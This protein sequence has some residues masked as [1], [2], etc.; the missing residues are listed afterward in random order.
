VSLSKVAHRSTACVFALL[1]RVQV[2]VVGEGK[3]RLTREREEYGGDVC[4]I[5]R[6]RCASIA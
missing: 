2:L 1:Y 3:R 6:V 5:L 4:A